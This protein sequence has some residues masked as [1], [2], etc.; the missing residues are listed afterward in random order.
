MDAEAGL[1][2]IETDNCLIEPGG[3]EGIIRKMP[4]IWTGALE[5]SKNTSEN[6]VL[7]GGQYFNRHRMCF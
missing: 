6:S 7:Y 2:W 5:Y 3:M 1:C 4:E